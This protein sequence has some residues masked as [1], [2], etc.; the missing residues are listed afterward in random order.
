MLYEGFRKIFWGFILVFVEIHLMVIDILPDPIGYYLI[1]SGVHLVNNYFGF[2]NKGKHVALGLV[3]LSLPTLF[4]QNQSVIQMSASSIYL[5]LIGI[6]NLVLAFYLFQLM[7]SISK[8]RE[9]N[10]L[11]QRTTTTFII[12]M[13]TMFF[14]TFLEAFSINM[15][16]GTMMWFIVF[17]AIFGLVINIFFL[18]LLLKYSK[19]SDGPSGRGDSAESEPP[20]RSNN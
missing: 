4:I 1:F 7:V 20:I 15:T 17:S 3:F 8:Q 6:L 5:S 10:P 18:A 14:L 11:H 16:E 13:V 19:L 9:D 2:N 12:Y